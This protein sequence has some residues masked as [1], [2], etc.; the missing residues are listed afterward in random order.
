M[1][2]PSEVY[3]TM[4]PWIK[5]G[6][7]PSVRHRTK[8]QQTWDSAVLASS[9]FVRRITG[10]EGLVGAVHLLLTPIREQKAR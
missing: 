9:E 5:L 4:T 10:D 2:D 7:A 8:D 1:R 6:S 3:K